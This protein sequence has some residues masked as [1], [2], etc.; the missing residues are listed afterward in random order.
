MKLILASTS[1]RRAEILH[2]AGFTFDVLPVSADETLYPN[3]AVEDYVRRIAT[4]K[5][6]LAAERLSSNVEP[7]ILIAADTVMFARGQILTKPADPD[8][9]R[10][11][12]SILSGQRHSLYSGLSLVRLPDKSRVTHVEKTIVDFA[13]LSPAIIENYIATGKS[14]DKA[15]AYAIHGLGGKFA[16]RIE[17]C[18]FNVMGLPLYRV[19][20]GLRSLGWAG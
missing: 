8:D 14:F 2:N 18:Y 13:P 4:M 6:D 5:A 12:L 1:P 19:W 17:G 16:S 11:M 15:G 10:R 20:L 3:E 7:A 9:A